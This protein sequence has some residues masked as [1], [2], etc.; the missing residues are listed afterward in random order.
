MTVLYVRGVR[1]QMPD[2][3]SRLFQ[4]ASESER[5][6][7]EPQFMHD[8]DDFILP[9]LTRSAVRA[10]LDSNSGGENETVLNCMPDIRQSEGMGTVEDNTGAHDNTS[11]E[12]DDSVAQVQC[13]N[14]HTTN[15]QQGDHSDNKD[16]HEVSPMIT[17]AHFSVD[18]EFGD[19][20]KYLRTG[21]LTGDTRK[22]KAT[23]LMSDRYMID[24]DGLL[25][26][27]DMPRQKALARLKP[28]IKRLC[29]PLCF[30]NDI[31]SYVHNNCGHYAAQSL[32]H[33]LASRYFWKT[34]FSDATE[35]CKTCDVCHR[36]KLNSSHRYVPL[37]PL[38]VP[39]EI[40]VRFA[41][42]HKTLTRITRA[43]NS[44]ILVIVEA[45]SGFPHLIPVPE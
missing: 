29:I 22:D 28:T 14:L 43:G 41:M 40:G 23:L 4:D 16:L 13:D 7:N 21:E 19:I 18:H 39:N 27:I 35:Y 31:I 20:Y 11:V 17:E 34:M 37:H 12:T 15:D 9:V 6:E 26:R 38:P 44:A 5:R 32:F 3:L 8:T 2:C 42:D 33:T 45:F 36:I 25:Y 10:S 30:R 1:N 24:Y